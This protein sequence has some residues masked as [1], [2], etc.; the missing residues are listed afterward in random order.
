LYCE[1]SL[2]TGRYD[3]GVY[4]TLSNHVHGRYPEIMDRYG[5]KPPR[6]HVSGM[7]GTPKDAEAVEFVTT[8]LGTLSQSLRLMASVLNLKNALT[9]DPSQLAW[10]DNGE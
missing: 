8:S 4:R 1:G 3:F 7:S 5:G 10:Y 9:A 6:W 2:W